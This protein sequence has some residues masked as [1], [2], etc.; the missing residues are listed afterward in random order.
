MIESRRGDLELRARLERRAADWR[1]GGGTQ[2]GLLSGLEL[3]QAAQWRSRNA[4]L[5][6]PDV[7][8][9]VDASAA[10]RRQGR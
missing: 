3:D 6:T 2:S 8:A 5:A 10:R 7:A 9:Y 1:E 4:D